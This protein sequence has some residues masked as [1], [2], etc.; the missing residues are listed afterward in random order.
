MQYPECSR[1]LGRRSF[2]ADLGE[3][4]LRKNSFVWW[5]SGVFK[6][7]EYWRSFDSLLNH[8]S[9]H[10]PPH[11]GTYAFSCLSREGKGEWEAGGLS[12]SVGTLT[13]PSW[14]RG[15]MLNNPKRG[16]VYH[17]H[18]Q[19]LLPAPQSWQEVCTWLF[20]ACSGAPV[21]TLWLLS[22]ADGKARV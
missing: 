11:M 6:C 12:W 20:T 2:K 19:K 15:D 16:R 21:V 5:I 13:H 9:G 17:S 3:W 22:W 8:I 4:F 1:A 10:I 14:H 7:R 18:S